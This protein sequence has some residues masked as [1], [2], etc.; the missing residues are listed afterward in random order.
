MSS[1]AVVP[2]RISGRLM[3]IFLQVLESI[4][5]L[6]TPYFSKFI[7]SDNNA[8]NRRFQIS[9]IVSSFMSLAIY[10]NILAHGEWFLN[11]WLGNYPK[12]TLEALLILAV[13]FTVT[14][15]QSPVNSVLI[16][17]DHYKIVSYL[18]ISELV[19]T[20]VLMFVLILQLGVIGAAYALTFS[21]LLIRGVLQ[22]ILVCRILSISIFRYIL[23]CILVAVLLFIFF[24]GV[25][26]GAELIHDIYPLNYVAC[27]LTLEIFV[28]AI[29]TSLS[30]KKILNLKLINF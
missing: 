8:F 19:F 26:W 9:L 3:E 15:M 11:I 21:M 2:L 1:I 25:Q 6:L 5:L 7:S 16:A 29:I 23:P 10:F 30:Y 24:Q 18:S 28:F 27:Y 17:K 14:N 22:P 20:L 4:D 12:V 13:G